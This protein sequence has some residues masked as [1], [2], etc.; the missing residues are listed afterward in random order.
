MKVGMILSR[1]ML[2]GDLIKKV[3]CF[4]LAAV[5]LLLFGFVA[6]NA[7][8]EVANPQR[9]FQAGASY[10]ISQIENINT[11]NGNLMLKIPLAGLPKARGEVSKSVNLVYNSKLYDTSVEIL[12]DLSNQ[13]TDQNMLIVSNN[14]GWKY[15]TDAYQ[16]NVKGRFD[17]AP[18][19]PCDGSAGDPGKNNYIWKVEMIFP[20]GSAKEFRP[21]GYT[22]LYNDGYFRISP[23]GY[24][25]NGCSSSGPTLQTTNAMVY[26]S[27]D[28]SYTKLVVDHLNNGDTVGRFNPWTMYLPDGGRITG[29]SGVPQRI[30]DRN[31]N[32][33]EGLADTLGRSI[34][35]QSNG[36][37]DE[38]QVT[39]RSF[40]NE[41]L[42]WIVKWKNI[43]VNKSYQT[44]GAMDRGRG[45]TSFQ[46]MSAQ[47]R[48]VDR[49]TLPTQAGS[50]YYEFHYNSESG[51]ANPGWGE[52]SSIKMPAGA[53]TIYEY[54]WDGNS[55]TPT[56]D[57]VLLNYPQKK[58][59][60][61]LSEY[62][63][64]SPQSVQEITQYNIGQTQSTITAPNGSVTTEYHG[65]T[66]VQSVDSGLV[67]KITNS[68][69]SI[70][71]R[72]WA[73]NRPTGANAS[74]NINSY[75][76]TEFT[77][78]PNAGGS[79]A[80]TAIKD[81][82]I[83]PNGNQTQVKE[84]DW[85]SYSSLSRDASGN[86]IIPANAQLKRTSVN[87][88]YN[89]V[90]ENSGNAYWLAGSPNIRNAVKSTEVQQGAA[91]TTIARSEFSY[92]NPAM[93]G[94]LTLTKTWDST[95]GDLLTAPDANGS[96]LN[97][98]TFVTFSNIYGAYGLLTETV[99]AKNNHT[100]YT[101]G[102]VGGYTNLYPTEIKQ[103][104]GTSVQR[105]FQ[106]EYD[107]H[108]GL[109]TA[110]IDVDNNVRSEIVYDAL[111]RAKIQKAAVGTA[112]EA[113]T[114][115]DYY[116]SA[117]YVVTKSDVFVKQDARKIAA[118]FY[119][120]LG[121]VRLSKTL[122]NATA[123]SATNETDGIKVQ[124]RYLTS[125]GDTYQ[126]TSNP[127]RAATSAAA[128]TEESMGWTRTKTINTGR[129]SEMETFSG[130][131][132]PAPWGN[133]T[134]SSGLVS[135]DV[136]ADRAMITDQA[137][138]KRISR[139]N[140]LGQLL[141]VWEIKEQDADIE[142]ISFGSPAQSLYGLKTS[143]AYDT[144]GNLATVTQGTQP[145]RT[146]S[147]SSLSRLLS[148]NNPESG[149]ISYEYDPNGN[150]TKKTD[151]RQVVTNYVYDELNRIKTRTYSAPSGL[152]NYQAS[153]PATYE[154]DA[155]VNA[156]GRL[157]KVS[158]SVSET[159]YTAFDKLGRVTASEQRTVS[160]PLTE[161]I[162]TATPRTMSYVYNLAG[163]LTEET[164][165][166]GRVVK[167][168]L[169]A[170]GD[171]SIVQSKKNQNA[172]YWNYASHFSYTAAGAVSSMQL[173]NGRWESTQFN[174]RLQPTQIALGTTP[175]SLTNLLK[176]DYTY[177]T[178]DNNGNV[179]TQIITVPAAGT[180]PAF[181]ATQTYNYDSLNRLKDASEVIGGNQTWKQTFNYDRFGNRTFN[182]SQTTT[183]GSCS[184][185]V[186]NP[187]INTADNRFNAGQGY[188]Y[189]NAGNLKT[190][191]EGKQF[192]YDA[193]NKQTE[194]KT[195]NSVS[196][197]TYFYDA[198]GKRVKK[199]VPSTGETTIFIYDVAGKLVAEYSTIVETTN[200]KVGYLT[201][202][203]LGSPRIITDR[204]GNVSSRRDFLPFG[205][206]IAANV[207]GRSSVQGYGAAD[208]V[209]E[210]FTGYERDIE[211]GLDFAQ[212][213]Y[214]S[215][216]HGRF[217]S[218]D[219]YDVNMERQY[220]SDSREAIEIFNKYV[221]N[222]QHWNHYAYVL[223]NPLKY[224]D[225]DGLAEK[226]V[227][228][229]NIVY[230]K[231]QFNEE[232]ARNA[233]AALL[234]DLK[235]VYGKID[236]EFNVKFTAGTANSK[237]TEI[238]KDAVSDGAINVFLSN[239]VT[240][241]N[242]GVTRDNGQIFITLGNDQKSNPVSSGILSHEVGHRLGMAWS[243]GISVPRII[244]Y[245][246]GLDLGNFYSDFHIDTTNAKA[247][248]GGAKEGVNWVDDY[249]KEPP[250]A[251]PAFS[252]HLGVRMEP[253]KP[254][255][256]DIYRA[257]ARA[258]A[259]K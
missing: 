108:S 224:V 47:L 46:T 90:A 226:L 70:T 203:H 179:K 214:Y 72:V 38:D 80:L 28:G 164:Y 95:K 48:V 37:P 199:V 157:T 171:L 165:P 127:Y 252:K 111:G 221:V 36:T 43:T 104:F 42:K 78:I 144:L 99:D 116:D 16:I 11:T 136:D 132:L 23:N 196:Q 57:K 14:G 98:N 79:P 114:Q 259:R 75:V 253:Y 31:G 153:Q 129:R 198:D 4:N 74:A 81:V 64:A 62:D 243:T 40:N 39:M 181:T 178:T 158:S 24:L 247:R 66:K 229:L 25:M 152:Q 50:I 65:D 15:D 3:A 227:V 115:I 173:G 107:F 239:G 83:D 249:T 67:K 84:Y 143:Y 180:A 238:S 246:G 233:A 245:I 155:A 21:A 63:G 105:T 109:P 154:Y 195:S 251:V 55:S 163:M 167:N 22:D 2:S 236:I 7:Q 85:V 18:Q 33:I 34:A 8:Q 106:T 112:Q 73:Y 197:G 51:A 20:D 123:Q 119:D 97:T 194:V 41:E 166:S 234:E 188:S 228:D 124:T 145:Q 175:Q 244:P 59:L 176:L 150:L 135:T 126:L 174:S 61:Y 222:P 100:T 133:N 205:E 92:D 182:A 44:T 151:A 141:N 30:Y 241:K 9:G 216:Y 148:A 149:L 17:S 161:T 213:R 130:A 29:G 91:Q 254:T 186:C 13:L 93:T 131:T 58:T 86:L 169:D 215:Y 187:S 170:E 255:T 159:R 53:E 10:S 220:A 172:G 162:A 160:D 117:R 225:P 19:I 49:I 183:L 142:S 190:D 184:Q 200:A 202:D 210:K 248:R 231:G 177:G 218:V 235:N 147:Y 128:A 77:T 237:K 223:N 89:S 88:Y 201:Q 102:A 257:G 134:A 103:A 54:R 146:F 168:V 121:R 87:S 32:Y 208:N 122:E 6:A 94:N 56:T 5:L 27:I 68:N 101:Y 12:P 250:R 137:G 118:Q 240:S 113:W 191:A 232:Q 120:Q 242:E 212:N 219:P 52:I 1:R 209:S 192:T 71:E 230:D 69:G 138:K 256:F 35:I 125:G 207:A 26:Y 139:T 110:S 156:K 82:T 140:A 76:K 185:T 258:L 96:R 211:L 193:D 206:E 204:N 217:T 189:D 60:T 45:G